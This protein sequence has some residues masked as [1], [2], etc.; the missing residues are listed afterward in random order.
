MFVSRWQ[1]GWKHMMAPPITP[2]LKHRVALTI[3][4]EAKTRETVKMAAGADKCGTND[5]G[6]DGN[7]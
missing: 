3:A 6:K 4:T 5:E 1:L 7:L 2:E